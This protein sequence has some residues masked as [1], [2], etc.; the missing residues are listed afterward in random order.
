MII[1]L[2][3]DNI[4][5]YCDR[6]I[7]ITNIKLVL[8][9]KWNYN[10]A[11]MGNKI[12][13]CW[14]L[15][16]IRICGNMKWRCLSNVP[17]GSFIYEPGNKFSFAGTVYMVYSPPRW[18]YLGKTLIYSRRLC[19]RP[20][21]ACIEREVSHVNTMYAEQ[22]LS[23]WCTNPGDVGTAFIRHCANP[24]CR[25]LLWPPC[26]QTGTRGT[27]GHIPAHFVWQGTIYACNLAAKVTLRGLLQSINGIS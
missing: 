5:H 26:V 9:L 14:G 13:I 21:R 2:R 17:W 20:P 1:S 16:T 18:R 3:Y 4:I 7:Y 12:T 24:L 25:P 15:H 23:E 8:K 10:S 27:D 11:L 6:L 19:C 22:R